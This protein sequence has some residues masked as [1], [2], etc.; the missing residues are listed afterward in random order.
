M[1]RVGSC[2]TSWFDK[3]DPDSPPPTSI[4]SQSMFAN[5]CLDTLTCPGWNAVEVR[6]GKLKFLGRASTGPCSQIRRLSDSLHLQI[7]WNRLTSGGSVNHAIQPY[8][9]DILHLY[10]S[11]TAQNT[12]LEFTPPFVGRYSGRGGHKHNVGLQSLGIANTS[13]SHNVDA[14]TKYLG[15]YLRSGLL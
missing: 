3:A 6:D 9:A 8:H 1:L 14:H 11:G 4:K 7:C 10:S 12:R 2:W 13:A 15:G 5:G